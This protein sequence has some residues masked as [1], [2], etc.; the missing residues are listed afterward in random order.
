MEELVHF[1]VRKQFLYKHILS[2][3]FEPTMIV[4]NFMLLFSKLLRLIFF[5][6]MAFTNSIDR[7][8]NNIYY[9]I[10]IL[11]TQPEMSFVQTPC[12]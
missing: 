9:S 7:I 2:V 5:T 6:E 4:D 11:Y 1:Y 12:V 3:I 8:I 10:S